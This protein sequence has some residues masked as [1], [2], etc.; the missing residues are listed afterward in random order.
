MQGKYVTGRKGMVEIL[1]AEMSLLHIVGDCQ[2]STV[3]DMLHK[4]LVNKKVCVTPFVPP[5]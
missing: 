2:P 4:C 5:T 1:G 3:I